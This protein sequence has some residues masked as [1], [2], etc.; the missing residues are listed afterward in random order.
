MDVVTTLPLPVMSVP[1][2]V[3]NPCL[4][5]LVAVS[6]VWGVFCFGFMRLFLK[7][8]F[9]LLELSLPDS[10][11]CYVWNYQA[12]FLR[13]APLSNPC[14][15]S[16][17]WIQPSPCFSTFGCELLEEKFY[18]TG[19]TFVLKRWLWWFNFDL[20]LSSLWAWA[21]FKDLW[22]EKRMFETLELSEAM[23]I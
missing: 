16:D 2:F 21:F 23:L 18:Q 3:E 7:K 4:Y 6:R 19:Q 8:Y 14:S 15:F 22:G 13:T 5:M 10:S 1:I 17:F 11:L 9:V 12:I 20:N